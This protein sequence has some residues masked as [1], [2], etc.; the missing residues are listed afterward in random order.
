MRSSVIIQCLQV[1]PNL[2]NSCT[3]INVRAWFKSGLGNIFSLLPGLASFY[4]PTKDET[5]LS[6]DCVH[7]SSE[8]CKS[9]SCAMPV[10][11]AP[12]RVVDFHGDALLVRS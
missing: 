2:L 6:A 7:V 12:G 5:V 10:P 4:E 11:H 3:C 8:Y 9:G 1:K